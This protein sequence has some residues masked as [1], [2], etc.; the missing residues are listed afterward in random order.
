MEKKNIWPLRKHLES[1]EIKEIAEFHDVT[2][3]TVRD[4]L[5]GHFKNE[6][7]INDFLTRVKAAINKSKKVDELL[8]KAT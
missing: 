4:V 5:H 2:P 6:A 1:Y 7:I 8:N 3:Q